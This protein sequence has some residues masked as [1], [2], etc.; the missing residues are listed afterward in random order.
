M[1]KLLYLLS[2]LLIC[3]VAMG[4]D[5][6]YI[7]SNTGSD[8]DGVDGSSGTPWKTVTY[9]VNKAKEGDILRL[10]GTFTEQNIQIA[11]N[12]TLIGASP[13]TTIIQ[14]QE[15]N[16]NDKDPREPEDN[17]RIIRVAGTDK[18]VTFQ[19]LT[20]R[21][22]NNT[23]QGSAIYSSVN[24]TINIIGCNILDC[25]SDQHGAAI[26]TKGHLT[27]SNSTLAG[28]VSKVNGGAININ[29]NAAISTNVTISNSLIYNNSVVT[30]HGGAIRIFA[31]SF[32]LKNN[33]IAY[34]DAPAAKLDGVQYLTAGVL[35]MTNNIFFNNKLGNDIRDEGWDFGGT[36]PTSIV[37]KNNI[38]SYVNNWIYYDDNADNT[39]ASANFVNKGEVTEALMKFGTFAQNADDGLYSLPVLNRGLSVNT[40]DAATAES[41]DIHGKVRETPDIGA[42]EVDGGIGPDI[43]PRDGIYY[44]SD[45]GDNDATGSSESPWRTLAFA[46]SDA[47]SGSTLMLSGTFT[48]QEVIINKNLTITGDGAATT[49][50]QAQASNPNDES[51]R[52]PSS[53]NRII[54]VTQAGYTLTFK[55]LTLRYGN[56]DGQGGAIY[57]NGASD[58]NIIGC[59]IMDCYSTGQGGGISTVGGLTIENS[60][61]INNVGN[62]HGGGV[63][64][65]ASTKNVSIS[66][67][68]IYNNKSVTQQGAALRV[69]A[70]TLALNN[71]TIAYNKCDIDN[72]IEGV[73]YNFAGGLTMTNNIFFNNTEA[74][75]DKSGGQDIGGTE[76][77]SIVSKNNIF[78][79]VGNWVYYNN[80]AAITTASGNIINKDNVTEELL[81]FGSLTQNADD[82]LYSL[83]VA[84]R[85]IAV[86]EADEATATSTDMHGRTRNMPD[87][88][89]YEVEGGLGPDRRPEDGIYYVSSDGN[90]ENVGSSTSPWAT[91]AFGV[92]DA[93]SGSTLM[94][95][96]T[97]TEQ[98]IT[99]NKDLTIIGDGASTTIL[100]AQASSP[101]SESPR[102]PSDNNRIIRISQAGHTLTLKDLT[103]RYGNT[104]TQG[105][106]IY[107]AASDII[108]SGCNIMDC[109]ATAQGGG[110]STQGNLTVENSAILNNVGESHGGGI[111]INANT[112]KLD[113]SNSLIYNNISV[114]QQGGGI[115]ASVANLTL[116]NNTIAYNKCTLDNKVEGLHNSFASALTITNNIFFNN[117]EANN[118]K[119]GGEDIGGTT[120]ASVIS[121]NNIFSYVA[122]AVYHDNNQAIT[123]ASGNLVNSPN[124]TEALMQFGSLAQGANDIYGLP[125]LKGSIAID[126]ADAGTAT[127]KDIYGTDRTTPDIGA[128]ETISSGENEWNGSV[129]SKGIAPVV[130]DNVTISAD[131]TGAGF[132]CKNL[133][134]NAGQ[135]VDI[136]NGT[137]EIKG[138]FTNNGAIIIKSGASL[139]TYEGTTFTGN[140]ITIE[141]NTRYSDGQ[142]S[143][144]GTIVK[145]NAKVK[146]SSLGKAIYKYDESVAYGDDAGLERWVKARKD[147]LVPGKGYTQAYKKMLTFKGEPNNGTIQVEGTYTVDALGDGVQ[148]WQLVAN[149]YPVA[150]NAFKFLEA[151]I[152]SSGGNTTGSIYLWDDNGSDVER[153]TNDDYIVING[154]GVVGDSRRGASMGGEGNKD[155]LKFNGG[156]V[157]LG[158]GQGFFVQLVDN[159]SLNVTFTEAMRKGGMN[160]DDNFFR[161]ASATA[162]KQVIKLALTDRE[163]SLYS[164]TLLGLLDKAT[165]GIDPMYDAKVFSSASLKLYSLVDGKKLA[166]QGQPLVEETRYIPLGMDVE[167]SGEY[168]IDIASLEN[169]PSDMVVELIDTENNQIHNLSQDGAYHFSAESTAD[170][171]RFILMLSQKEAVMGLED[172]ST[173][174][175]VHARGIEFLDGQASY[176]VAILDMTGKVLF[177]DLLT[178]T[179]QLK[180]TFEQNKLYIINVNG[181][182]TKQIFK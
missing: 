63:Y 31:D 161:T 147:V 41:T 84:T 67:S 90:D 15:T 60:A 17:V 165:F 134:V 42:F 128:F 85:G 125:I 80:G 43:R 137:L 59:N 154:V 94:L 97:F 148:G 131:Y 99:I 118:N 83:P 27:I 132:T 112:K 96:G 78:S 179:H 82:G 49:I 37:S 38:F 33:T 5:T 87:I 53:G 11:K 76:P 61:I 152:P 138:D 166:I 91:L 70:A 3:S 55:D 170:N 153:G 176:K 114:T 64:V 93:E 35:T 158:A 8:A 75:N 30:G 34:N 101:H 173:D 109:Y 107:A 140:D 156:H 71:N 144:V 127:T 136:G 162:T 54:R 175:R 145:Q 168:S 142:Y 171:T 19:N 178:N 79:Y 14:A 126:A 174:L 44:V 105:G 1:K 149:P 141:R 129:W 77:T 73:S 58:I 47:E 51:P 45:D 22:G 164:E 124:V 26:S 150:I 86:N 122:G 139:M 92:S 36:A 40:A 121:K 115:R 159:S 151:N 81:M 160:A 133:T 72:K 46:V 88:G 102:N 89:A 180:Y 39:T 155:R 24:S 18:T 66:N 120:P 119:L 146:G 135:Q 117:T 32:T 123:T 181:K 177:S 48:E 13:L 98:N 103:L 104:N 143:F 130:T 163:E 116:N 12:L 65:N 56:I 4:Q 6:Y 106:A 57:A 7:N 69:S 74:N 52:S 100:Q 28:N 25:Y 110:I 29:D 62:S 95:S 172:I 113:I 157:M 50:L 10:S 23:T 20:L 169:L 9:A 182:V 16:P 108:I 111:Y 2:L 68:L 21:Y 167:F